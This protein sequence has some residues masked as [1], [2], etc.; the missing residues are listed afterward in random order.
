MITVIMNMAVC[1]MTED[2]FDRMIEAEMEYYK[3]NH[4]KVE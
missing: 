3:R 4:L 2:E 1:V